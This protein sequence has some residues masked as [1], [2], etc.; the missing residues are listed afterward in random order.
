MPQIACAAAIRVTRIDERNL[1]REGRG[2]NFVVFI[3][4]SGDAPNASWSV[5]SYLLTDTDLRTSCIGSV[6]ACRP[7]RAGVLESCWTPRFR[8]LSPIQ[9]SG[10]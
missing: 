1:D 7:T 9:M 10:G 6:R 2:A 8:R 4:E 5:D 3:H